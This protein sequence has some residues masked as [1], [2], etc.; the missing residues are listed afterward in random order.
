[1]VCE[2]W[3]DMCWKIWGFFVWIGLGILWV[4]VWIGVGGVGFFG[5][6]WQRCVAVASRISHVDLSSTITVIV[7][8]RRHGLDHAVIRHFQP[9]HSTSHSLKVGARE[10]QLHASGWDH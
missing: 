6:D 4:L 1:M 8:T 9:S 10:L 5:L 7:R 3:L 2:L